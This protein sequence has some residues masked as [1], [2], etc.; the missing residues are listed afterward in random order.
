MMGFEHNLAGSSLPETEAKQVKHNLSSQ[1]PGTPTTYSE[2]SRPIS[3]G[4][5]CTSAHICPQAP[6][7][8]VRRVYKPDSVQE[9]LR[10]SL[11]DHSSGHTFTRGLK[12][13]TR[14]VGAKA[15]PGPKAHA[16]PIRP[17][18]RRG[19]PCPV[20]YQPGGGLLPHRFTLP[21]PQPG[22]LFSVALSLG[23]PRPGVTRRR[24]FL[25]SGLSSTLPPRSSNPPHAILITLR[26][27]RRK[28]LCGG[29]L[30]GP[31]VCAF[32]YDASGG[33]IW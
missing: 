11:N 19:L 33:D 25:E 29:K 30:D 17:C 14:I 18:S 26:A 6:E 22:G 10:P 4:E 24:V 23:L 5:N 8:D 9:G 1:K 21:R 20:C 7:F 3:V 16:I 2:V 12:Q 32:R 28:P 31:P 15:A 13:P 27:P